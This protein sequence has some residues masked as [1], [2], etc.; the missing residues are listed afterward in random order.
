M[1]HLGDSVKL[2]EDVYVSLWNCGDEVC[3]CF[4]PR[5]VLTCGLDF[6]HP[7]WTPAKLLWAGDFNSGPDYEEFESLKQQ[8]LTFL[9][10]DGIGVD[11]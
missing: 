2:R 11:E 10:V 3:C 6:N 5:V 9:I 7:A 8:M 1:G 4:Q